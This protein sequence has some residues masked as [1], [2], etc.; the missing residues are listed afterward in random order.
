MNMRT[1][2]TCA[3][4]ALMVAICPSVQGQTEEPEKVIKYPSRGVRFVICSPTGERLPSPLYA[5]V[6]NE[7]QPILISQRMPS[8]R[9]APTG[10][11]VNFYESPPEPKS[12]EEPYLRIEIPKEHRSKSIC[13]VQPKQGGGVEKAYFL[14]ETDFPKGSIYVVNISSAPLEMITSNTG[15]F[16]GEE[17]TDTISA[18]NRVG[19]VVAKAP[20]VWGF[21]S[22]KKKP[23]KVYFVLSAIQQQPGA[24]QPMP[25][26]IRSSVFMTQPK[27]TQMSI[28]IDQPGSKG[29]FKLMSLQYADTEDSGATTGSAGLN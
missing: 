17:K 26:R 21:A 24:K 23:Q 4:V 1:I 7:Y 11:Y 19:D 15:K 10:G 14:R 8:P 25:I 13:V 6:G 29:I 12:K 9:L 18:G 16:E 27:L 20:N 2:F 5:K 22:S 3:L 28:I